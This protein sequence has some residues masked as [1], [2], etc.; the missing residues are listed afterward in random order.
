MAV[1]SGVRCIS[2]TRW[3]TDWQTDIQHYSVGKN[4]HSGKAKFCYC[5]S[6]LDRSDQLQQSAAIFSCK[7]VDRLQC[8]WNTRLVTSLTRRVRRSA[9]STALR[10]HSL[11]HMNVLPDSLRNIYLVLS[12][13]KRHLKTFFFSSYLGRLRRSPGVASR[14]VRGVKWALASPTCYLKAYVVCDFLHGPAH[15]RTLVLCYT[16]CTLLSLFCAESRAVRRDRRRHRNRPWRVCLQTNKRL[17]G[18]GSLRKGWITQGYIN[19]QTY[20]IKYPTQITV[21][22]LVCVRWQSFYNE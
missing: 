15:V 11:I 7:T 18:F 13:F 12:T 19:I 20:V 10:T 21:N 9:L 4:R 22:S 16:I 1:R 2:T 3:Q 14:L 8:M 17:L 5:S 6:R